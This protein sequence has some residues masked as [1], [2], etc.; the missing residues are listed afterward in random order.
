MLGFL[1]NLVSNVLGLF[2]GI[3]PDDPFTPYINS[4]HQ[5]D[6]AL[7]WLNWVLPVNQFLV[8]AGL[9][10]SALVLYTLV[11]YALDLVFELKPES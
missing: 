4:L 9:W 1:F 7:G 3:L 5:W 10:L 11:R 2:N 8:I 6:T